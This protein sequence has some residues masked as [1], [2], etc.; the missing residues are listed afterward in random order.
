MKLLH[1]K[2][3]GSVHAHGPGKETYID[4]TVDIIQIK[5]VHVRDSRLIK[6]AIEFWP[7]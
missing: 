2:K 7:T 5:R 1:N 4:E 3:R 6:V